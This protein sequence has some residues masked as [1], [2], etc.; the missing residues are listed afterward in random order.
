MVQLVAELAPLKHTRLRKRAMKNGMGEA[1]VEE[2]EDDLEKA[3]L[4]EAFRQFIMEKELLALTHE[5]AAKVRRLRAVHANP[6]P[7]KLVQDCSAGKTK[8]EEPVR[9]TLWSASVGGT[10]A[11]EPKGEVQR[12]LARPGRPISQPV[13][14]QY[15]DLM[16][17]IVKG[18]RLVAGVPAVRSWASETFLPAN[19]VSIDPFLET[20]FPV[21]QR[22]GSADKVNTPLSFGRHRESLLT[23][24]PRT[25]T[26]WHRS[27]PRRCPRRPWRR[28][29]TLY[30]RRP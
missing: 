5:P 3:E 22:F 16:R 11:E 1:R 10:R 27:V 29:K 15:R 19:T 13:G 17:A 4:M 14:R 9:F 8:V 12:Q 24:S 28:W 30:K 23:G 26:W 21:G 2:L 6:P 18:R 25:S 7:I 20:N